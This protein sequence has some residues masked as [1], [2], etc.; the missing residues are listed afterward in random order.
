MILVGGTC[1]VPILQTL[2]QEHFPSSEILSSIP[3]DHVVA[4]GA[5][6]QGGYYADYNNELTTVP[7]SIPCVSKNVFIRVS[8]ELDNMIRKGHLTNKIDKF[9]LKCLLLAILSELTLCFALP[10]VSMLVNAS[11]RFVMTLVA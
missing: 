11:S 5:A 2:L 3:P 4:M 8:K 9:L 6:I 7:E 10:D 1:K